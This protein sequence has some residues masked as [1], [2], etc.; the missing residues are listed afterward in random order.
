MSNTNLWEF[1][2]NPNTFDEI[3]LHS[4]IKDILRK[5]VDEIPNMTIAGP[6]GCGK[7]TFMSVLINTK[8]LEVLRLNGSDTNGVDDIRDRVKPFA[9]SV[10]FD[11]TIKL[12]YI[13][14]ADRLTTNAQDMLRD[15]IERVQDVTRFILVCNYPER[16]T[17]ELKSRC[18]LIIYP[19]PP[20]KDIVVKC[21]DIL[22]AEGITFENKDVINLV[23][24]T[25]PD[26]RHTINMLKFNV[27][28]GILSSKLNIVSVNEVYQEVLDAMLTSDPSNVRKVLRSNPIDYTKL[29]VFLYEKLMDTKTDVFKNDFIAIT[30]VAEGSYRNDIVAIKEINF[31]NTFFKILKQKAV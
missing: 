26:I 29:F 14:E 5:A 8:K 13:N 19:D 15:L 10:G 25:Y 12:V 20:I 11:G 28:G 30:E 3:I 16:I 22:K 2:Y 7:G 31:M 18:P 27:N 21:I 6:P 9:E 1:R 24:S 4:D 17:K 23:K